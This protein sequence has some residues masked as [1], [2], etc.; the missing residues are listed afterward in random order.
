MSPYTKIEIMGKSE[1]VRIKIVRQKF[2]TPLG[3]QESIGVITYADGVELIYFQTEEELQQWLRN[4]T[5][6]WIEHA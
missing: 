6:R 5:K 1:K 2:Y 3:E 4:K